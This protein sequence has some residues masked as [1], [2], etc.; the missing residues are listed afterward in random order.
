MGAGLGDIRSTLEAEAGG[1]PVDDR[2]PS[3]GSR[4]DDN[5]SGR[6]RHGRDNISIIARVTHQD[7]QHT[8]HIYIYIL[9][10]DMRHSQSTMCS[11]LNFIKTL[12]FSLR[13][14][15]LV[16]GHQRHSGEESIHHKHKQW[17]Q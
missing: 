15:H 13:H 3:P 14:Q 6:R 7:R 11:H 5:Q 8:S 16:I 4:R 9:K 2:A 12:S 1:G 17:R 10:I